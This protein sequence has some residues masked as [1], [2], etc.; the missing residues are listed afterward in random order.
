[1]PD[2]HLVARPERQATDVIELQRRIGSGVGPAGLA[3]S[4]CSRR[5]QKANDRQ[6]APMSRGKKVEGMTGGLMRDAIDLRF[7]IASGDRISGDVDQVSQLQLYKKTQR[8]VKYIA[9]FSLTASSRP[10]KPAAAVTPL[11]CVSFLPGWE[12]GTSGVLRLCL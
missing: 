8:P 1:M 4:G 5:V 7:N 12:G 2:G 11:R 9:C 3:G 6:T 10:F